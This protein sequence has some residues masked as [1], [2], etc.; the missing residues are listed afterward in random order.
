[1][2]KLLALALAAVLLLALAACGKAYAPLPN[3][4]LVPGEKYLLDLDYEQALLQFDQAIQIDPKNPRG[5]LGKADALLHL[6]RQTD[7]ASALADGAKATGGETRA[8]LSAAQAEVNQSSVDGYVGLSSAY[9][10]LGWREI[11]LALLKRVCEELPE[12]SRLRA[13]LEALMNTQEGATDLEVTTEAAAPQPEKKPKRTTVYSAD[14]QL[15]YYSTCE[16]DE[17]GN[18]VRAENHFPSGDVYIF[19]YEN[20]YNAN[21]QLIQAEQ[22]KSDGTIQTF[23]YLYNADG[24]LIQQRIVA[25]SGVTSTSTHRYNAQ[26]QKIQTEAEIFSG[27]GD[28]V[29]MLATCEYNPQGQ[30]YRENWENG[31]MISEY[32][33]EG[34]RSR[35]NLYNSDGTF[36]GYYQYDY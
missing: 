33:E 13:A 27:E 7:A 12:E 11:A 30:L 15:S 31:Y 10:K 24:Q 19:T 36:A 34:L 29:I 8:A 21:G 9:E 35:T 17:K 28:S 14:G 4:P 25:D 18:D 20:H 1:M 22:H 23:T 26:G 32:D 5:Y 6:D 3:P 16:Y 2:K